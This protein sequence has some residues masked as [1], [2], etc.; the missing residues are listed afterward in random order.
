[1]TFRILFAS[2]RPFSSP[3]KFELR[4]TKPPAIVLELGFLHGIRAVAALLR[5]IPRQG[6][7]QLQAV[8]YVGRPANRSRLVPVTGYQHLTGG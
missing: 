1:V 4:S 5:Q 3:P 6:H 8:K 2:G 7:R